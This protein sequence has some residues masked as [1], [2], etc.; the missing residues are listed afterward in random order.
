MIDNHLLASLFRGVDLNT[1]I[2]FVGDEYQLPSVGPGSILKDMIESGIN[3]I[4]LNQIYRQSENSFI[5][6]LAENIRKMNTLDDYKTKTDDYAFIESSKSDIKEYIKKVVIKM[7]D[8]NIDLSSFQI[9]APMYKSINKKPM[10]SL[11]WA[12]V[13][14]K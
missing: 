9:L 7:M 4:K 8:K 3:H 5:P 2:I 14:Y 12:K 6:Y 10:G 1:K 11:P 13:F